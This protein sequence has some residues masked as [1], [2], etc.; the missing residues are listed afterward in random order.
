MNRVLVATSALAILVATTAH[1]DELATTRSF[2]FGW[3][4]A[5]GS[6]KT[7][8]N[9]DHIIL[10][11][12]NLE[13]RVA[14]S[15]RLEIAASIP[16]LNILYGNGVL[17]NVDDKQRFAW[18]DTFAVWY[19]LRDAGGLFIAPGLG[20]VWGR[21]ST[22][23]GVAIEVPARIGWEQSRATRSFARAVALRPWFDVVLPSGN[24]DT[25][26]RYGVLFELTLVGYSTR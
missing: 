1:A 14:L 12:A 23:S 25:G 24:V 5:A 16:L 7:S 2:G 10:Q 8:V 19:P 20:L 26:T 4:A 13:A 9:T 18:V 22:S 17:G 3:G 6:E 11:A 15:P 21:T